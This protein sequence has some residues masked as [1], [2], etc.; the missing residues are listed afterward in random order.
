MAS[1]QSEQVKVSNRRRKKVEHARRCGFVI[2]L[3]PDLQV[4]AILEGIY[5]S[6]QDVAH[7]FGLLRAHGVTHIVNAATGITNCFPKNFVYLNVDVLDLPTADLRA[8]FRQALPFMRM[9][10]DAGGKVHP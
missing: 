2:D 10:V 5:L 3:K 4:A 9:A 6:S 8:H 1:G 7:D